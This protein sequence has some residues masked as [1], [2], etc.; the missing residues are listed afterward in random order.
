[1]S[2]GYR[3][4]K[5]AGTQDA[6]TQQ[7]RI[8]GDIKLR[9]ERMTHTREVNVRVTIGAQTFSLWLSQDEWQEFTGHAM[10]EF[11]IEAQPSAAS[12]VND[13]RILAAGNLFGKEATS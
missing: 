4:K 5:I 6:W 2:F 8:R 9:A 11:T 12:D 13:L 10:P 3:W 1:M 7:S